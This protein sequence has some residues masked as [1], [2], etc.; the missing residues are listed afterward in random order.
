MI[1]F[2]GDERAKRMASVLLGVAAL[3]AVAVLCARP[4]SRRIE[5]AGGRF[6][7]PGKA[8]V[9]LEERRSFRAWGPSSTW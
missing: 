1:G 6:L 7:V 8:S 3:V 2:G 4:A 5:T 9:R